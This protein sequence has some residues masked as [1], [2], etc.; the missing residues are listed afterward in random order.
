MTRAKL[1][2]LLLISFLATGSVIYQIRNRRPKPAASITNT[3]GTTAPPSSA[4]QAPPPPAPPVVAFSPVGANTNIPA[5][6]WGR[7]PFLTRDEI[8]AANK[9]PEPEIVQV[10]IEA[11]PPPPEAP[12][13]APSYSV[14]AI[15]YGPNGS[16]AVVNSRVVQAG[17]RVG[18]EIVK[19]IKSGAV[20]LEYDGRTR[21]L[22]L[23]RV[24]SEIQV[25]PRGD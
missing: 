10:P 19:E 5:N 18:M 23:K 25:V 9:Q 11:A 24:G 13:P 16:F 22:P 8:L 1:I 21:E 6:G 17:D 20:V 12:P 7:N 15:I 3:K 2:V 14:T 4:V